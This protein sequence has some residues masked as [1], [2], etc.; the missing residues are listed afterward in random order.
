MSLGSTRPQGR[1]CMGGE[2]PRSDGGGSCGMDLQKTCSALGKNHPACEISEAKGSES[3]SLPG[4]FKTR[5]KMP[6]NTSQGGNLSPDRVELHAE[7]KVWISSCCLDR[8]H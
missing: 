3:I 8:R 5:G 7:T 2:Q 1:P 6:A 4:G